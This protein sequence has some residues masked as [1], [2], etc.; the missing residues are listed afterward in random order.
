MFKASSLAVLN[1]NW[2][3]M[4]M[5]TCLGNCLLERTWIHDRFLKNWT[6]EGFATFFHQTM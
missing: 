5:N 2:L 4:V 6:C 1:F 3:F